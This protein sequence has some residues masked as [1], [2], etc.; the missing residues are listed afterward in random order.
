M[1]ATVDQVRHLIEQ[2]FASADTSGIEEVNHRVFGTF[3]WRGFKDMSSSERNRLVTEK[4]RG[5][6]GY[7]GVNVGVLIPLADA[8]EP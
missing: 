2:Q 5:E 1:A 7:E 6:L 3:V 8:Q 4:V